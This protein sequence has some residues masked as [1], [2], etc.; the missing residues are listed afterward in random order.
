MQNI[1]RTLIQYRTSTISREAA[2]LTLVLAAL[3]LT[4]AMWTQLKFAAL[5]NM[6]PLTVGVLV[7]DILS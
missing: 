5:P 4:I 1:V 3:A 2:I 6:M 7:L